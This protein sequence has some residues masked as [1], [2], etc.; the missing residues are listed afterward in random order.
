[1]FWSQMEEF[2]GEYFGKYSDEVARAHFILL[3][4][5]LDKNDIDLANKISKRILKI[6][7]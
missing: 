3:R 5:A 6:A 4:D 2:P 1:M 7:P